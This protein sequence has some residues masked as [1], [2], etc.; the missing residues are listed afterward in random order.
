MGDQLPSPAWIVS[1]RFRKIFIDPAFHDRPVCYDVR[2]ES[3]KKPARASVPKSAL[4]RLCFID[5]E[6]ASG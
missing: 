1:R 5:R 4:A 3:E 2:H 6:I